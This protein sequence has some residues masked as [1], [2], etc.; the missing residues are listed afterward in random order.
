MWIIE[1][2]SGKIDILKKKK[3][4]LR[5]E[6]HNFYLKN[7]SSSKLPSENGR[8]YTRYSEQAHMVNQI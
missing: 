1:G 2:H 3:E 7:R 5:I 8:P 4:M 6:K